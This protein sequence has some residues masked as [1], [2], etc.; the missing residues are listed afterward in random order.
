MAKAAKATGTSGMPEGYR[1]RSGELPPS[2]EPE[3]GEILQG[4]VVHYK[5]EA[6][7]NAQDV[8]RIETAEGEMFGVWITAGLTGRLSPKDIGHEVYLKRIQDAAA[9][10]GQSAMKQYVVG[11]K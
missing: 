5:V 6:G 3:V 8:A 7:P 9:K 11:I 2:W 10:R 1:P 4:T